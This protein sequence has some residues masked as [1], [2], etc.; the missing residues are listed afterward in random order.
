MHT[1]LRTEHIRWWSWLSQPDEDREKL[2][3]RLLPHLVRVYRAL[4]QMSQADLAA[5]AKISRKTVNSL[6]TGGRQ[7]DEKTC[8]AVKNAMIESGI[9]VDII[10]QRLIVSVPVSSL[11]HDILDNLTHSASNEFEKAIDDIAQKL[12]RLAKARIASDGNTAETN[13]VE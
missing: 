9:S 13:V 10:D 3:V 6:E 12:K 5:Q 4:L 2:E 1:E 8:T 11:E 7:P